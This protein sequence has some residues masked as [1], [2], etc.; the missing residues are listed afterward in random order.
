MSLDASTDA[1]VL[2]LA[3]GPIDE[4]VVGYGPFVMNTEQ[5]IR[6]AVSDYNSGRLVPA[7][8]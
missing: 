8:T 2:L 1:T 3:G 7:A 6:Q 5:E 4:R